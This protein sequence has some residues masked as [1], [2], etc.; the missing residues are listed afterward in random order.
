MN[1]TNA[2]P[3]TKLI[4]AQNTIEAMTKPPLQTAS[5]QKDDED[6]ENDQTKPTASPIANARAHVV[7][8]EAEDENEND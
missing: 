3:A 6:D 4:A 8:T 5:Q 2:Q 7:A 1:H